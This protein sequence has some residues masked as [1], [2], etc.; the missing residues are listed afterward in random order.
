MSNEMTIE[1]S[2]LSDFLEVR[3]SYL[4][5]K[6]KILERLEF[7]VAHKPKVRWAREDHVGFGDLN[8]EDPSSCVE[9]VWSEC[10]CGEYDNYEAC[11]TLA[12]LLA[13]TEDLVA[14]RQDKL[15][16]EA[17]A[18]AEADK[19]R[20]LHLEETARQRDLAELARL[21]SKYEVSDG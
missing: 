21:K 5:L 15:R 10:H 13:A 6:E 14:A 12:E 18:R 4:A 1:L 19:V 8:L 20:R 3:R 16:Q 11:I 17:E 7:V 2:Q 9:L